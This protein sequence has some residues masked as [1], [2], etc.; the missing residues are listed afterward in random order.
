MVDQ[1]DPTQA[2]RAEL[3]FRLLR[4]RV[5]GIA[6]HRI[7]RQVFAVQ[8]VPVER[9]KA[10][11]GLHAVADHHRQHGLATA[12]A[13][14]QMIPVAHA[15]GFGVF[16]VHFDE[17]AGVQLVQ[18]GDLAG[19]G[20]GVPLVLQAPGVEHEGML[21]IGHFRRIQVRTGEELRLAVGRGKGQLRL[22]AVFGATQVL[23]DAIVEVAQRMAVGVVIWRAGPL[24][25]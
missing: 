5:D 4:Q 16:R 22:S 13:D 10:G 17:G 8:I 3:E 1:L 15:E 11:A 18:G 9:R 24:Q 12:R 14:F 2:D 6:G 25:R 23:A 7:D 21:G 20:Q 19:L